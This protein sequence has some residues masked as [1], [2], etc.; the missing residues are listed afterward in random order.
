MS[1]PTAVGIDTSVAVPLLISSHTAHRAVAGWAVGKTLVLS[2]H[3][4]PETYAVITRLPAD[5]RVSA[6][7][8][9]TLI[10]HNFPRRVA[11]PHSVAAQL[12][13]TLSAAGVSGGSTYDGMVA[14]AAREHG[15]ALATRDARAR[16]TYDALGV[17]TIL[18]PG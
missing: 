13:R 12:H 18:L 9:A 11:L 1:Q 8:A 10:D 7:D 16:T 5:A 14:L 2:G 6:D 17:H 15:L 3:A 4:L